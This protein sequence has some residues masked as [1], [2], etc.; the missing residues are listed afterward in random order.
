MFQLTAAMNASPSHTT[1]TQESFSNIYEE[2]YILLLKYV[3]VI[4]KNKEAAKDVVADL[5]YELWKNRNN[6]TIH[7]NIKNY[8]LVSARRMAKKQLKKS[9]VSTSEMPAGPW[10]DDPQTKFIQKENTLLL[11]KLLAKLS[12]AK[13]EII[14]LR[15]IGLTYNEIA[16]MLNS[17][18][19]KIEYRLVTAISLLQQEIKNK[20]HLTQLSFL[21]LLPQ[22]MSEVTIC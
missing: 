12:P 15:L 17:T 5:F 1:I 11:D 18:P 6:L 8:L 3:Y 10:E 2:Y 7:T 19:K 21:L 4:V 22:L 16:A 13:Q 20:P 14:Q 9:M